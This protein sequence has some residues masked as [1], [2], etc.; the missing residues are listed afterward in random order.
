VAGVAG[1]DFPERSCWTIFEVGKLRMAI[2][3]FGAGG[4]A[5]DALVLVSLEDRPGDADGFIE[6]RQRGRFGGIGVEVFGVVSH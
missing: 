5:V 4:S 2:D 3:V 1:L 6:V